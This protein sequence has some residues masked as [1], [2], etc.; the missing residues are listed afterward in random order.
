MLHQEKPAREIVAWWTCVMPSSSPVHEVNTAVRLMPRFPFPSGNRRAERPRCIGLPA[1]PR[2]R[3][4]YS[5]Q[6]GCDCDEGLHIFDN[7]RT[8]SLRLVVHQRVAPLAAQL[9][10]DDLNVVL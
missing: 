6:S 10:V 8:S 1:E 3:R 4:E 7:E 5:R 9:E 2:V